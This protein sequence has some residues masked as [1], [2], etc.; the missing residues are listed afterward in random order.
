[1]DRSHCITAKQYTISLG[2][3]LV[4]IS[5]NEWFHKSR[6]PCQAGLI[7][8]AIYYRQLYYNNDVNS[9]GEVYV[10]PK[11]LIVLHHHLYHKQVFCSES[12][13]TSIVQVS[14]VSAS[15]QFPLQGCYIN[16][17]LQLQLSTGIQE[18]IPKATYLHWKILTACGQTKA[19]FFSAPRLNANTCIVTTYKQQQILNATA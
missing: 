2:T 6:L 10:V 18:V 4:Q 9:E 7:F 19:I 13:F 14:I 15:D 17:L 1:M 11:S 16:Y 5:P 8:S 3:A 12:H